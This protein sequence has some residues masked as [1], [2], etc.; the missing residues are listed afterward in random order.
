MRL[1]RTGFFETV[2]VERK[3]TEEQTLDMRLMS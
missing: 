3:A 1:Q 2:A